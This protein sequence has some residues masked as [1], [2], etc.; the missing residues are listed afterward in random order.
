MVV[1]DRRDAARI[2]IA[3]LGKHLMR[4]WR[5]G[6]D[7][8]AGRAIADDFRAARI[9]EQLARPFDIGGERAAIHSE[10]SLMV[11]AV[12]GQFMSGIDNAAHQTGAFFGHPAKREDRRLDARFGKQRQQVPQIKLPGPPAPLRRTEPSLGLG[13]LPAGPALLAARCSPRKRTMRSR[14]PGGTRGCSAPAASPPAA[15]SKHSLA[16]RLRTG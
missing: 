5:T 8:E 1:R 11:I 6:I 16:V 3:L 15:H 14:T 2:K 7:R 10:N 4:P 12:A 13:L 9:F